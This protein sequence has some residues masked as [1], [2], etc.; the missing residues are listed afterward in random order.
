MEFNGNHIQHW[1]FY[2][3]ENI[4]HL[5]QETFL[6]PFKRKVVFISNKNRCFAIKHQRADSLIA[7][8]YHVVLLFYDSEWKVA[9]LDSSMHLPCPIEEYLS[10][11]F[12]PELS[13]CAPPMFRVVDA[14]HFIQYFASD[15]RHMRDQGGTFLKPPPPLPPIRSES[16]EDFNLW[17]FVDVSNNEHGLI[18][19]L[20]K[21]YTTFAI[22]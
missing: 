15:R 14:D 9:D 1:P 3:E 8:D 6:L 19:D 21:M 20:K 12:L 16:G 7:W 22:C 2:C 17:N 4:W 5:C 10:N 13:N 18:Y 11:S